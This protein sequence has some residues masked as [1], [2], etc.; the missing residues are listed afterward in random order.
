[1][2]FPWGWKYFTSA[3]LTWHYEPRAAVSIWNAAKGTETE[4]LSLFSLNLNSHMWL[5]AA[6]LDSAVLE[7][8]KT[9]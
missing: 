8:G 9:T 3:L 1:M 2:N 6:L 7:D 4:F 5:V